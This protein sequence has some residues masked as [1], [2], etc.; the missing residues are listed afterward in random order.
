MMTIVMQTTFYILF[1]YVFFSFFSSESLRIEK[2]KDAKILM[3]TGTQK[4]KNQELK[5]DSTD[6]DCISMVNIFCTGN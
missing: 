3:L 1:K 6:L 2:K 4:K 5:L